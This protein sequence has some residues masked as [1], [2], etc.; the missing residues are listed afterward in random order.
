M[1]LRH[2]RYF[3]A[4]GSEGSFTRAAQGLRVAQSAVSAQVRELEREVGVTLLDRT[5][6]PV[7]L[8][9]AGR[10]FLE[11]ASRAL[12]VVDGAVREAR[13]LGSA[14]YGTLAIGFTGS[15]SHDSMPQILRRFRQVHPGIEVSLVEMVPS[16]QLEALRA[17]T[18]DVGFIGPV[19]DRGTAGLRVENIAEERPMLA[20]PSDHPLALRTAVPLRELRREPFVF[21]SRRNSPNF[22]DWLARLFAQAGFAPTVVQ[23]VDRART[24]VQYVAAGFGL[25]IFAE[26]ISR[27]PAPGVVFLPL[28]GCRLKI[29]YGL[30]WRQTGADEALKRF[31]AYAR[32]SFAAGAADTVGAG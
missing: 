29:R 8:T 6:H 24:G 23:E 2:L 9:A 25:S 31:V 30:A 11:D 17:K 21:T 26:H 19:G 14:G 16:E 20:V 18:L 13:R 27:L 10:K 12:A 15:Q 4:V 5:S 7:R 22:R 1:E 3:A 28:Q 32:E